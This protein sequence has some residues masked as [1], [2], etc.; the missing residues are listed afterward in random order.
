MERISKFSNLIAA[1]ILGVSLVGAAWIFRSEPAPVEAAYNFLDG[2]KAVRSDLCG[3]AGDAI[4]TGEGLMRAGKPFKEI[5]ESV[6]RDFHDRWNQ[7]FDKRFE[8]AFDE[9]LPP[10]TDEP[11]PAQRLRYADAF[12]AIGTGLKVK[13]R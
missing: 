8:R 2:G 12:H 11:T 10:G 4:L 13:V 1:V 3:A 7:A 5:K 9:I 6:A